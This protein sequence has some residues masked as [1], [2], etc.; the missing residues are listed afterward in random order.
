MKKPRPFL[1]AS[2]VAERVGGYS[3]KTV[4][5]G[6][7]PFGSLTRH[8]LPGSRRPL[9]DADEVDAL[10]TQAREDAQQEK[11]EMRRQEKRASEIVRR[12]LRAVGQ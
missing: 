4:L 1:N 8:H 9:F 7:P 3:M 10:I 2:Q 6:N 5:N 11:V 12:H